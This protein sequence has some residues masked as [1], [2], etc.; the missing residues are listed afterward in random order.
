MRPFTIF[1]TPWEK[2]VFVGGSMRPRQGIKQIQRIKDIVTDKGYDAVVAS[3]FSAPEDIPTYHK[4]LVLLHCCKYAIFDLSKQAGQLLE[5]I[6]VPE[7][8]IST[9]LVWTPNQERATTEMLRSVLDIQGIG[10]RAYGSLDEMILITNNFLDRGYVPSEKVL[11]ITEKDKEDA[12][13]IDKETIQ[14]AFSVYYFDIHDG[15][16]YFPVGDRPGLSHDMLVASGGGDI[17]FDLLVGPY[18]ISELESSH[19]L[20]G[21]Y[22][23]H[24][25]AE[26]IIDTKYKGVYP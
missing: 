6:R 15:R 10:H 5:I 24:V 14:I 11:W 7:Y 8:G 21:N 1:E 18:I 2:R 4:C 25:N 26:G 23:W 13:D 17:N 9:L 12:F 19:R 16:H 3:D 22:R 20:G